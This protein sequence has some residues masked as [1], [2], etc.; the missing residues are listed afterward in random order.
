[1]ATKKSKR[2]PRK[3]LVAA[4]KDPSTFEGWDDGLSPRERRIDEI[5]QKMQQGAWLSGV[6]DRVLAKEWNLAPD[7]VR[8]LAAEASRLVR[9]RLR[10]DP[11]AKAEAKAQILQ[12]FEVLRAKAM[13]KGDA[14]SL[15]VAL[16][17]TR[18]L[19]FYLGLEP[20]R[21][22][23]VADRTADPMDGWT[24]EEKISYAE[25]GKLPRRAASNALNGARGEMH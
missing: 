20:A 3:A 5:A 22:L 4:P 17:A 23:D 14:Q 1:M 9:M 10:D 24:Q 25:S 13:A 8:G 19:G 15:R 12:T 16:D 6:S 11:D 2:P 7:T 21:K 18:A